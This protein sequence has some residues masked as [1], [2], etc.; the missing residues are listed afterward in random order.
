MRDHELARGVQ[1]RVYALLSR[2]PSGAAGPAR[3]THRCVHF[4]ISPAEELT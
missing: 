3:R 4:K 2:P 1:L